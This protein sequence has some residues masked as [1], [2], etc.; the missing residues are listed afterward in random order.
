V[1]RRKFIM[2]LGGTAAW[3]LAARAQQ[4]ERMRRIAI[5]MVTADDADGQARITALREGLQK[6]GWTEGH[7]LRIDTRW[8]AGDAVDVTR[9]APILID[10]ISQLPKPTLS[11][12]AVVP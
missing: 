7:N 11:E 6:L 8:A 9:R 1:K 5:V 2:L 4:P 3:P 12:F 10:E